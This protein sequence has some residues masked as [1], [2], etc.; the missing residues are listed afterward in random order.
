MKNILITVAFLCTSFVLC[1]LIQ[2][3]MRAP[4]LIPAIFVLGTFLT[5]VITEGY[6]YGIVSALTSVIAVNYAFTFPFF[7]LNFTIPE[8]LV[9]AII[10]IVVSLITCALT[11]KL[12][13]QE[14]LKLDNGNV[15]IIKTPTG[16]DELIASVP[17]KFNKRYPDQEVA[18]DIPDMFIVIPMD[19]ILIEPV[20]VNIL[21]A[22]PS[23]WHEYALHYAT[24]GTAPTTGSYPAENLKQMD[25]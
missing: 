8:N 12:R 9:S 20:I 21:A 11:I 14:A 25:W 1:L 17:I 7:K 24:Y 2:N 5:S 4:A 6:T 3:T 22:L 18:V 16:L 15:K 19:A 13:R 10:M 23:W